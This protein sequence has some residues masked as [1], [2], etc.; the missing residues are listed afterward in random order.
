MNKI[1]YI[2]ILCMTAGLSAATLIVTTNAS[3]GNGSL[4]QCIQVANAGDSVLFQLPAGYETIALSSEIA[5]AKDLVIDGSNTLG[6]GAKPILKVPVTGK[7]W[8]NNPNL[9]PSRFR[10]FNISAG[11]VVL[12]FL[13]IRGGQILDGATVANGAYLGAGAGGGGILVTGSNTR[14]TLHHSIISQSGVFGTLTYGAGL[15][16]GTGSSALL[17][18]SQ[19]NGN[20]S[21]GETVSTYLTAWSLGGGI[22]NAG[23]LELHDCEVN[24]NGASSWAYVKSAGS[25]ATYSL[26]GAIYNHGTLQADT[27]RLLGNYASATATSDGSY[28]YATSEAQAGAL[29]NSGQATLRHAEIRGN[30]VEAVANNSSYTNARA[31]GGGIFN[32]S[33]LDMAQSYIGQNQLLANAY[34]KDTYALGG[35]IFNN[36]SLRLANCSLH[37]NKASAKYVYTSTPTAYAS[38]GGL[39]NGGDAVAANLSITQNSVS[40]SGNKVYTGGAGITAEQGTFLLLNSLNTGNSGASD[41]LRSSGILRGMNNLQGSVAIGATTAN[42]Q[43]DASNGADKN[44][45]QLFGD[46]V[47]STS[48]AVGATTALVTRN[49]GLGVGH[50]LRTAI[51]GNNDFAYHDGTVWRSLRQGTPA[52]GTT[53]ITLDQRDLVRS[54]IPCMGAYYTAPAAYRTIADGNMNTLAIWETQ[55]SDGSWAAATALPDNLHAK[56]IRHAVEISTP[57][58]GS[59]ILIAKKATLTITANG[60]LE[61]VPVADGLPDLEIQGSILNTRAGQTPAAFTLAHGSKVLYSGADQYILP[62]IYDT[63]CIRNYGAKSF[64]T[65]DT[66]HVQT[67]LDIE[68]EDSTHQAILRPFLTGGRGK[69]QWNGSAFF[70]FCNFASMDACANSAPILGP[71]RSDGDNIDI[72]IPASFQTAEAR[73]IGEG[74]AIGSSRIS[75]DYRVLGDKIYVSCAFTS[76]SIIPTLAESGNAYAYSCTPADPSYTLDNSQTLAI[77]VLA[78]QTLNFPTLEPQILGNAP[79]NVHVDASSGNQVW[80]NSLTPEICTVSAEQVSLVA[81]GT[82][83]LQARLP[84]SATHLPASQTA[85]FSISSPVAETLLGTH[86]QSSRPP[87]PT[88]AYDLQGRIQPATP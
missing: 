62:A 34:Y 53:E 30:S 6:S 24:D 84:G 23:T 32:V 43:W 69:I 44:P 66:V 42:D 72:Q 26:G 14:L 7:D 36:G 25:A 68:G 79:Y 22:Y 13:D 12:K 8:F 31:Y 39:Y 54:G 40:A 85:S 82:C 21:R 17:Y 70:K 50:G 87:R 78:K 63:L 9:S 10:V 55:A 18:D 81:A 76:P 28:A 73:S 33:N 48:S 45:L 49:S 77:Q 58:V 11:N 29:R 5:I 80:L 86:S 60:A 52:L 61:I 75:A 65:D 16:I 15:Y 51:F 46:N 2:L 64:D 74:E 47:A 37:A 41:L 1:G 88:P 59:S 3:T 71:N 19:V 67:H 83:T 56:T 38:G 4:A 27:L 57:F 35:G 20:Y